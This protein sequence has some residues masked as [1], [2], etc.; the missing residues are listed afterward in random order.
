MNERLVLIAES[1]AQVRHLF[2]AALGFQDFRT[3]TATN[4]AQALEIA[5]A[6]QPE[7][8]VADLCMPRLDGFAVVEEL[9]R[10]PETALDSRAGDYRTAV[11]RAAAARRGPRASTRLLIT[12][13]MARTL[14]GCG[15]PAHR[16]GGAAAAAIH[17]AAQPR[18]RPR[19]RSAE[20]QRGAAG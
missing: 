6:K 15:A 14:A 1:D 2:Q 17:P 20:L 16:A 3:T 11:P 10:D 19:E 18:R 9:K 8:I 13:V 12:P 4:G 7:L 5:R